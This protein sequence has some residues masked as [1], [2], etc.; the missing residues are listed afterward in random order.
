MT[1]Q[2]V[3]INQQGIAIASDT[4]TTNFGDHGEVKTIPSNTKIHQV[5]RE[6]LLAILHYGGVMLGSAQWEI[7]IREWSLSLGGTLPHLGDYVQNF[8][9]WLSG[10]ADLFS[11]HEPQMMSWV[12]QREILDMFDMGAPL[13]DVLVD[14]ASH[15]DA[16]NNEEFDTL[17]CQALDEYMQQIFQRPLYGDLTAKGVLKVLSDQQVDVASLFDRLSKRFGDFQFGKSAK[18]KMAEFASEL[19]IRFVPTNSCMVLN[20]VGF[21]KYD[22]VGQRVEVRIRSF[23]LGKLRM[24]VEHFGSD[25]I[26]TYPKVFPLAQCDAVS[27]FIHGID[28]GLRNYF[29]DAALAA[30]E[31]LGQLTD[32]QRAAFAKTFSETTGNYLA[33]QYS[34]PLIETLQTVGLTGLTRF[35]EMMIRFQC[36]RAASLAGEATVGGFVESLSISRDRG[37][38]WHERMSLDRHPIE[39]ASHVFA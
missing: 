36:L 5:G 35:A 25:D 20:F 17:V 3:A 7:L 9:Q 39:T 1:S 32:E 11:F 26:G 4:L 23:Y 30:T 8:E 37:I 28:S 2:F 13:A 21:G 31:S 24:E 34:Q 19:L 27:S 10:N 6:H 12:I 38:E 15:P 22:V 18:E 33:N 14:K 16:T 29:Q